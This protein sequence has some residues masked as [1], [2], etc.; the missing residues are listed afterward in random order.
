MKKSCSF[1]VYVFRCVY[2]LFIH[3]SLFS[4]AVW[5]QIYICIFF[6]LCLFLSFSSLS[7]FRTFSR[8][9][10]FHTV[11][12][13][14]TR[15]L[16]RRFL[17]WRTRTYTIISVSFSFS[18]N[19]CFFTTEHMIASRP[20]LCTCRTVASKDQFIAPVTTILFLL[21]CNQIIYVNGREICKVS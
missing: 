20:Y 7:F 21:P 2:I 1:Y 17:L 14:Y 5:T 18:W 8:S 9:L 16:Y 4:L 10:S 15:S 3:I 19:Q 11:E 6:F 12:H 13:I